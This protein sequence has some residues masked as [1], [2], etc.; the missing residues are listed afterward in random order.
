M[1]RQAVGAFVPTCRVIELER[2]FCVWFIVLL[3]E[4]AFYIYLG[5]QSHKTLLLPVPP[6]PI[7]VL[8]GLSCYMPF[9]SCQ[10]ASSALCRR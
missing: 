2:S 5:S 10:A 3:L 6:S 4:S 9:L 8:L 1:G 7:P